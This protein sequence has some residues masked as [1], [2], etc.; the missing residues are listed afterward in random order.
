M[1]TSITLSS[2]EVFSQWCN[3]DTI[4]RE[5]YEIQVFSLGTRKQNQKEQEVSHCINDDN[6]NAS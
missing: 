5:L 6:F 4:L 2:Y 1:Y 3:T